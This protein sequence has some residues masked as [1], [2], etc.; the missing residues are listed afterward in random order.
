[1]TTRLK[2]V[3]A[4]LGAR[5]ARFGPPLTEPEVAAFEQQ[6]GVELPADYR[7]FITTIGHG[8]PG[9]H[10]GLLR[11][12]EWDTE[13]FGSPP[14]DGLLA[15]PFL[16]EPGRHYEDWPAD[17][18]LFDDED[19]PYAGTLTL[20]GEGCGYFSQLVV[21][22]AGRGLVVSCG[23]F[24]DPPVYAPEGDFLS[25]YERWLDRGAVRRFLS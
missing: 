5:R 21:T 4:E 24:G 8:G 1:V 17:V 11:L 12:S 18:G 14:Y 10:Y 25:W 19:E 6:H 7:A 20:A 3:A 13:A 9:P 15:R 16:A 2:H 23:G 22:G